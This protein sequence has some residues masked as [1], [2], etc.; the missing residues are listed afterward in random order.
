MKPNSRQRHAPCFHGNSATTADRCWATP[1]R[2][3]GDRP[4]H[5]Q[6]RPTPPCPAANSRTTGARGLQKPCRG[7]RGEAVNAASRTGETENQWCHSFYRQGR[8]SSLAS[9]KLQAAHAPY[10]QRPSAGPYRSPRRRRAG[11][12]H[13]QPHTTL[14]R[15]PN[16]LGGNPLPSLPRLARVHRPRSPP[17]AKSAVGDDGPV[18]GFHLRRALREAK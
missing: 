10:R 14:S 6:P 16:E 8:G 13:Q 12:T 15:S 3:Q 17:V 9:R 5:R 11:G 1:W 2:R 18:V 4:R 7:Y